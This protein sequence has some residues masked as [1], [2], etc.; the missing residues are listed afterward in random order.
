MSHC[1][2]LDVGGASELPL[3]TSEPGLPHA[4]EYM[5]NSGGNSVGTM[6][7]ADVDRKWQ[8]SAPLMK[9]ASL[10]HH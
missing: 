10:L 9:H 4:L 8:M 3:R 5:V 1:R 7:T 2:R 6:D